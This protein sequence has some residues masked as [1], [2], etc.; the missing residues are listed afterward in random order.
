MASETSYIL[1]IQGHLRSSDGLDAIFGF[2]GV[3]FP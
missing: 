1:D 3:A 2:A